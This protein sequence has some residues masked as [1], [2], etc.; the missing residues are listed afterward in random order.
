MRASGE[1]IE[2]VFIKEA[3]EKTKLFAPFFV[4]QLGYFLRNF[5]EQTSVFIEINNKD[6]HLCDSYLLNTYISDQTDSCEVIEIGIYRYPSNLS[7]GMNGVAVSR[8]S[9]HMIIYSW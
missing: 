8:N 4:Y 9:S 6:K 3:L 1:K 5:R 2:K 7:S